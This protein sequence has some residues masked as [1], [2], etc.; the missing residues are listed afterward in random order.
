MSWNPFLHLILLYWKSVSTR[1]MWF[2]VNHFHHFLVK[3]W[4]TH[5]MGWWFQLTPWFRTY[6]RLKAECETKQRWWFEISNWHYQDVDFDT[7]ESLFLHL[8][9]TVPLKKVWWHWLIMCLWDVN[10]HFDWTL[11]RMWCHWSILSQPAFT[12]R[13]QLL[14]KSI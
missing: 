8:C 10:L 6:Q 2:F 14:T 5:G 4:L 11:R 1:F 7:V 3:L 9:L 12:S 13:P